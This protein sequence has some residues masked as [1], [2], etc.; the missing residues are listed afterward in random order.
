MQRADLF[1]ILQV[2]IKMIQPENM[3]KQL[4]LVCVM[5]LSVI[6][7]GQTNTEIAIIPQPVKIEQKPGNFRLQNGMAVSVPANQPDITRPVGLFLA[8]IERSSGFALRQADN[9][10]QGTTENGIRITLE[11]DASIGKEGYR[12]NVSST[13]IHIQAA[14][15]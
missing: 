5:C 6:I 11:S 15:P 7:H 4:A 2:T 9:S 3:K 1:V 13:G 12:L 14:Q 8:K 10:Q